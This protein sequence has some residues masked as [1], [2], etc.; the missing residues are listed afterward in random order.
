[1]NRNNYQALNIQNYYKFWYIITN[2]YSKTLVT[3]PTMKSTHADVT[4][5]VLPTFLKRELLQ[6]VSSTSAFLFAILGCNS[7]ISSCEWSI[8]TKWNKFD[9]VLFTLT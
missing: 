9:A 4:K 8:S 1:M 6:L 2:Y 3:M 7:I 5:Q